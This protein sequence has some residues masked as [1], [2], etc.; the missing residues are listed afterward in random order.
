MNLITEEILQNNYDFNKGIFKIEERIRKIN[1]GRSNENIPDSHIKAYRLVKEEIIY[2]WLKYVRAIIQSHFLLQGKQIDEN[3]LMQEQFSE[4]LWE[5]IRKFIRN[6]ANLPIWI[7]REKTYLFSKRDYG[8]WDDI[9][10]TGTSPDGIKVLNKGINFL[11]M[12]K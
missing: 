11:E 7:D 6:L 12:I 5:N 10:R 3:K 9:F 2:N 1:E 8:Y 4:T